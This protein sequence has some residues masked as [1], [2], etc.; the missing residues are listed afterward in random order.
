MDPL[1]Y[2]YELL[3]EELV[4]WTGMKHMVACNSGTAAL[5]LALESLELPS[6]S[7]VIVP[8]FTM[9]A[10]PRAV[11]MAGLEPVFI[12]CNDHLNMDDGLIAQAV[13]P[14][15][16]VILPVHTYGRR[17]NMDRIHIAAALHGLHVVEDMAELHG[18][19]PHQFTDLACWS[20]YRNKVVNGE[21]GGA[22]GSRNY[23]RALVAR[24]LRSLGFNDKH[25]YFHRPR[26]HNYR[27]ANS[28]ANLIRDSLGNVQSSLDLRRLRERWY[29]EYC[30]PQWRMPK[31]DSVWVYDLRV[32]GLTWGAQEVLVSK[33]N[34]QG[35]AARQSFKPMSMQ[36]E[37]D[38]CKTVGSVRKASNETF[39]LPT[40]PGV[41]Y[42]QV[43]TTMLIVKEFCS[44]LPSVNSASP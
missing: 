37:F 3:E 19:T 35:I 43:A 4:Q 40:D 1:K 23:Y 17:C 34:W 38:R 14:R 44:R 29:D 28:L 30:P 18:V 36:K 42:D 26:G 27:L 7:E 32:P 25:D 11:R 9:V 15:T 20:F 39:Y 13:T 2:P 41:G 10:V 8:D 12:G 21:E 33:L 6:G 16:R 31:R 24:E 22:V 5:H